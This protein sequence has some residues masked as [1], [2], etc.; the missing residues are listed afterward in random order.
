[1]TDKPDETKTRLAF[2]CFLIVSGVAV[3]WWSQ[4][5]MIWLIHVVGE[6]T[7][8]GAKNVYRNPDGTV[9]LTN[10]GGMML[11]ALPFW[12][13]GL[14]AI[15]AGVTLIVLRCLRKNPATAG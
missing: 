8:L 2:G 9:L 12:I 14:A 7:A 5:L 4:D 1:M 6:E 13:P 11:W 15:V 3:L 10:P